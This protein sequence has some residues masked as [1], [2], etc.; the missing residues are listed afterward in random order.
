MRRLPPIAELNAFEAAARRMSFRDAAEELGV[1]AR[2]S[3]PAATT[4]GQLQLGDVKTRRSVVLKMSDGSPVSGPAR[5]RR[6]R[7]MRANEP[8]ATKQRTRE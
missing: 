3:W 1:T 8:I 2:S 7:P 6:A 5:G 4:S